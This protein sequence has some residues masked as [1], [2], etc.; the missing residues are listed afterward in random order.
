MKV[1]QSEID[2]IVRSCAED[3]SLRR[4][5]LNIDGMKRDE[6]E[7]FFEKVKRYFSKCKDEAERQSLKFFE[8]VLMDDIRSLIIAHLSEKKGSQ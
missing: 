3:E 4:I 5:V 1:F 7:K 6:R 2:E 8:I